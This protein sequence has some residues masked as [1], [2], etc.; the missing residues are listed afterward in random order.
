MATCGIMEIEFI[1]YQCRATSI[2][3]NNTFVDFSENPAW[4]TSEHNT[5]GFINVELPPIPCYLAMFGMFDLLY[6]FENLK[7]YINKC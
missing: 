5:F 3:V 7:F 6:N 2:G 1:C 4:S